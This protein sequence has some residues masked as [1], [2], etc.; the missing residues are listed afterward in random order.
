MLRL[1]SLRVGVAFWTIKLSFLSF[2]AHIPSKDI[3]LLFVCPFLST[4]DTVMSKTD[5]L[6]PL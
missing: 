2:P 3:Y 4:G 1:C 6:P 5:V